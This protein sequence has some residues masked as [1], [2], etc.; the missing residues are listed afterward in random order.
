MNKD[1]S[2]INFV[3]NLLRTSAY[4]P[5]DRWIEASLTNF[6]YEVAVNPDEDDDDNNLPEVNAVS[7][8]GSSTFSLTKS[9]INSMDVGILDLEITLKTISEWGSDN[10]ALLMFPTKYRPDLGNDITC[11]LRKLSATTDVM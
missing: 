11:T 8:S 9:Y 5:V 10:T 2:S 1:T 7:E 6:G 3:V 4:S